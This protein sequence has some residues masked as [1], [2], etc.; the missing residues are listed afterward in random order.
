MN[1]EERRK[2]RARLRA[3]KENNTGANA[4]ISPVET[5]N[6]SEGVN[7]PL[8]DS[9]SL[10]ETDNIV[11]V[12]PAGVDAEFQAIEDHIMSI[13]SDYTS[14]LD[15]D[16]KK[17]PAPWFPD[18]MQSIHSQITIPTHDEIEKLDDLFSI[19]IKVCN[20]VK[21]NPTME[22][23]CLMIGYPTTTF[24]NWVEGVRRVTCIHGEVVKKWINACNAGSL[25]KIQTESGTNVNTIFWVKAT[26]GLHEGAQIADDTHSRV[27]GGMGSLP[28]LEIEEKN[29][30]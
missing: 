26:V 16:E 4:D 12:I 29:R 17:K 10:Y 25:Y 13:V 1:R 7:I 30:A 18:L 22:A 19:Y 15:T 8:M 23:F 6:A 9:N 20:R 21:L 5:P 3:L 24:Y 2:E 11:E 14:K 27:V 28:L